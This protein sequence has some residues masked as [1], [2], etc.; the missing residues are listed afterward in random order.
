MNILAGFLDLAPRLG[1]RAALVDSDGRVASFDQMLHRS[2]VVAA[3]WRREG[4]RA[5]ERVLVAMPLGV[6]LY[7]GLAALWRIGA[8]AV[9]PE[10]AL[11]LQ[12]L[13]YAA[14]VTSPSAFMTGGWY[15]ALRFTI[16]E[17]WR[18]PC[19]LHVGPETGSGERVLNERVADLSPDAPALISFT[20]G[21]TGAPKAIARSHG[22]LAAQNCAVGQLIKPQSD[23][24]T[25]LVAFPVFVIAN[26][27]LGVTSI[28]PNW[29]LRRHHEADASAMITHIRRW[30]IKRALIPPSIC[31]ILAEARK[32]AGLK[33]IFTGGGPV[34][35]DMIERIQASN[36]D[37]DITAVY[38]STEAEPIAHLHMRDIRVSDWQ[39]MR[40]GAGL[41][42]GAP[43]A[44]VKLKLREDEIVVSGEHVNKGYLDPAQN[45]STKL[46]LDGE[47]WHRTGDAGRLDQHGRLW[48]LGR[49]GE[50][51]AGHYPFA[52]ETAARFW[53]GVR[54]A[55]L[56]T[57][58]GTA[59]LAIEGDTKHVKK[60]QVEAA[61]L[62]TL[63]VHCL[64]RI[65]FDRRHRSKVD[66]SNLRKLL[67]GAI[68]Q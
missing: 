15:Q 27:G 58:D 65:P 56:V 54:R 19:A 42:A 50:K 4:L 3:Q 7:T 67:Q 49:H 1:E 26:L 57:L 13:R 10:P 22:F 47:V 12:G 51:A 61:K 31:E 43:V 24:E 29:N 55:A 34:F 38:G 18:I 59:I 2:A 46:M 9:F 21:S 62:G 32:A 23:I 5:G 48:L 64:T 60:W 25:D 66:Y 20:S 14:R 28:L 44:E 17:I 45:A 39:A 63:Q 40:E 52:V 35:P 16:P 6:E 36:P 8:V 53:P 30:N 41:L 33:A 68:N 37:C 11:G